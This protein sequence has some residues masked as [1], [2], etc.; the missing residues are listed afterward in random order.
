M[1]DNIRI[2]TINPDIKKK[3]NPD[4]NSLQVTPNY[5]HYQQL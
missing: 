3:I 5:E 4:I 1:S 2:T